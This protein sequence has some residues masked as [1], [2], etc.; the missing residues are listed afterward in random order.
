MEEQNA[1]LRWV[2]PQKRSERCFLSVALSVAFMTWLRV[3]GGACWESLAC[4]ECFMAT[5][6]WAMTTGKGI[7]PAS[8]KMKDD[9]DC[10]I[11]RCTLNSTGWMGR[12]AHAGIGLARMHYEL[13][14]CATRLCIVPKL[15]LILSLGHH[16]LVAIPADPLKVCFA[17][18]VLTHT[19]LRPRYGDTCSLLAPWAIARALRAD[20]RF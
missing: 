9:T 18:T 8:W 1:K 5:R 17:S 12:S 11:I 14:D 13:T 4:E 19:G 3:C 2:M 10:L 16:Y 15:L 6:H 7:L 20:L